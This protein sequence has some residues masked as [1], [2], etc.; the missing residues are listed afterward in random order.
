M[1]RILHP[2]RSS[3][4]RLINYS[5]VSLRM[6][7]FDASYLVVMWISIS[8]VFSIF[9][10]SHFNFLFHTQ[11]SWSTWCA[12][13]CNARWWPFNS[14]YHRNWCGIVHFNERGI[15]SWTCMGWWRYKGILWVI[16]WPQVSL[17]V[18][19]INLLNLQKSH[20][21]VY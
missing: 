12:T 19:I 10:Y 2:T 13:S 9:I 16:T 5:V 1:T 6:F 20:S 14:S 18:V 17:E 21:A 3:G 7:F 8:I 11:F 15:Y 4:S